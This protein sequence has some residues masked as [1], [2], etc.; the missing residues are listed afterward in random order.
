MMIAFSDATATQVDTLA[1]A[2]ESRGG[3]KLNESERGEPFLR[4]DGQVRERYTQGGILTAEHITQLRQQAAKA[5][6]DRK[7]LRQGTVR[8]KKKKLLSSSWSSSFTMTLTPGKLLLAPNSKRAGDGLSLNLRAWDVSLSSKGGDRLDLR[9][10]NADS[11][12][13]QTNT[14]A[15]GSDADESTETLVQLK[16]G[17]HSVEHAAP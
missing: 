4:S 13:T 14:P 10:R 1:S 8:R 12:Q 2:T 11:Q 6:A 15:S 16:A 17:E 7:I 9:R 5:L 3:R